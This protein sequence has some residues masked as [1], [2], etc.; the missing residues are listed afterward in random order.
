M[1]KMDK[2][3]LGN[4]VYVYP[5]P[6]AL[7]GANVAGRA[8]FMTAAWLNRVNN[9]PP[10]LAVAVN[11]AHYTNSGIRENKT[12]SINFPSADLVEKVDYC[13]LV[14]GRKTDKSGVFTVFYGELETAPMTDECPLC[15]E[16][17]LQQI[18]ELPTNDLFIGEIVAGYTEADYLTDEKLDIRKMNPLLLT[19]PDNQ[20]WT[21]GEPVGKAWSVGKA[22]KEGAK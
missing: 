6:V 13:G 8:N 18:V 9:N 4:I 1:A 2:I 20:Y 7:V 19:M 14:S 17:R 12:F 15:L 16:C 22:L 5:M 11:R 3:N 10:F 21:V